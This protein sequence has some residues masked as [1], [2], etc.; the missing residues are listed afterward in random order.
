MANFQ[1]AAS[2]SRKDQQT[3]AR[4]ERLQRLWQTISAI[5]SGRVCS[6]GEVARLA[7]IP[8]GARQTAWALRQLAP[9][10]RIPW[11]RVINAQG[12]I[13]MPEGS[14]GWREQRRRLLR[15]GV[16]FAGN[17][18]ILDASYWWRG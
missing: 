10:S 3:K 4:E 2:T 17:G 14:A 13:A 11:H 6:Y 18:R 1:G 7:G 8:N 5:P 15:E 12:R 16:K 9:D